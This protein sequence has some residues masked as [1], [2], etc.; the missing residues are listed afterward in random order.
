MADDVYHKSQ[1]DEVGFKDQWLQNS[2]ELAATGAILTGAGALAVHGGPAAVASSGQQAAK[3][4]GRGFDNF[5][6]RS[7]HPTTRLGYGVAKKTFDN[8]RRMSPKQRKSVM[9]DLNSLKNNDKIMEK[10]KS[11][12]VTNAIDEQVDKEITSYLGRINQQRLRQGKKSLTLD[13]VQEHNNFLWNKAEGQAFEQLQNGADIPFQSKRT[14]EKVEKLLPKKT[15]KDIASQ[16]AA[17]GGAG[18]AFGAG[19]S[20]FHAADRLVRKRDNQDKIEEA[21]NLTGSF[22]RQKDKDE[23]KEANTQSDGAEK[24]ALAPDRLEKMF[25]AEKTAGTKTK[26]GAGLAV[27]LGLAGAG[28][29]ANQKKKERMKRQVA[30][31]ASYNDIYENIAKAATDQTCL[32]LFYQDKEQNVTERLVEPYELK[33]GKLFAYCRK[34]EGIRAF[35]LENIVSAQK[36]SQIYD[37]RFPIQIAPVG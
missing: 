10:L 17:S 8:L 37:A 12:K 6:R 29:L 3:A 21:F 20:G 5:M 28:M 33:D 27:G 1:K 30:Y 23:E 25:S 22:L 13:D 24:L 7:G 16:A 15:K 32:N 11:R 34:R 18:L 4:A 36:T 26:A 14:K 35:K 2:V 9:D 31:P 19:L